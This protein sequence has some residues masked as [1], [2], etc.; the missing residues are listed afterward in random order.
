MSAGELGLAVIDTD[1]LVRLLTGDDKD[2]QQRARRLFLRVER[3][4]LAVTAPVTVIADTF[5]V[6]TSPSL[7]RLP[8]AEA[9][10]LLRPILGLANF[11]VEN[12]HV[13]QRTLDL[14]A[15]ANLS[16]GDAYI[17]A[18]M[19]KWGSDTLYSF[20]RGFDRI[21]GITRIEP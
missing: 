17:A 20:D 13:V 2:K 16:F 18:T 19:E 6:L 12:V 5:Y 9:V 14:C 1:V 3:G 15:A 4:E 21:K 10:A 11:H 8:K 7:Y